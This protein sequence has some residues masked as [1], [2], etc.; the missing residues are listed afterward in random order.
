MARY[1]VIS[2]VGE[3]RPGLV[4]TLSESILESGANIDESRM[5]LLGGE[6]AMILLV[7]GDDAVIV[8]LEESLPEIAGNIGLSISGKET[9]P[10]STEEP[11][12]PYE[13]TV[14]AMD[15]PGI[16]HS[17]TEFFSSHGINIR[18]LSTST[19]AAPHTG[20]P[21]F[22]MEMVVDIPAGNRLSSLRSEFIDYCDEQMIDAMIEPVSG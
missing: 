15:Q 4:N 16:V 5:A 20:A 6:F 2:A 3:D 17:V 13:V 14:V 12:L 10:R 7:S 18:E 1:L 19:Y 8:R 21:M 22:S 9:T 11:T